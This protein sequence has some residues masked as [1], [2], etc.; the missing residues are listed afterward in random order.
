[1]KKK[2]LK[3]A[4]ICLLVFSMLPAYPDE[5]SAAVSGISQSTET[6]APAEMS[7]ETMKSETPDTLTDSMSPAEPDTRTDFLAP[8]EPEVFTDPVSPAESEDEMIYVDFSDE[9]V[10]TEEYPSDSAIE[11]QGMK[12]PGP[13]ISEETGN[14]GDTEISA[15]TPADSY[16]KPQED[17]TEDKSP[18]TVEENAQTVEVQCAGQTSEKPYPALDWRFRQVKDVRRIVTEDTSIL[19]AM[20]DDAGAA[21]SIKQYGLVHVLSEEEDGWDYVESGDVRGFIRADLLEDAVKL[22]SIRHEA[23]RKLVA[24]G[25]D[26]RGAKDIGKA[27]ECTTDPLENDAYLY[28]KITCRPVVV[29]KKYGLIATHDDPL[30][31]RCGPGTD[32]DIIA[33]IPKGGLA[34][35]LADAEKLSSYAG[36][37][38]GTENGEKW[39]YV[40]SGNIKG[41]VCARYVTSGAE[42]DE[43]IAQAG[44]SSYPQAVLRTRSSSLLRKSLYRTFTSV[45][46]K[47]PQEIMAADA[48]Y[49]DVSFPDNTDVPALTNGDTSDASV[50]TES[51][52]SSVPAA[53]SGTAD[54]RRQ[55]IVALARSA[56][57]CPYVWGGNDLYNGCDCSGFTQQ[58]YQRMGISIP[59]T[60]EAQAFSGNRISCAEAQPGDLIFYSEGGYIHHAAVFAGTDAS[61]TARTIEAYGSNYGIIETGAFGRDECWAC[62]WL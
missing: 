4:G 54:I 58:I 42:T 32:H 51:D 24:E 3:S 35:I 33:Q 41:F 2:L 30:N 40:E 52:T 19:T 37:P 15:D 50:Q 44:E 39:L 17:E 7:S 25:K 26:R 34:Y 16:G 57:G 20:K 9:S 10:L 43:Q 60:A 38:A 48:A 36:E 5:V 23:A 27:A 6:S 28:K 62:T 45:M 12:N 13:D 49:A 61:G 53:V 29:E 1:M 11:D 14:G 55:Q 47:D 18:E 59:R 31:V 8:S 56:I 22:T 21:G 46:E